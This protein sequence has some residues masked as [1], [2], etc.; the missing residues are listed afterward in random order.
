MGRRTRRRGAAST[1]D[2]VCGTVFQA[3]VFVLVVGIF[4][5]GVHFYRLS[6]DIFNTSAVTESGTGVSVQFSVAEG[7]SVA[8]IGRE[9][10]EGGLIRDGRA[11]V[12]QERLSSTHGG[13]QPGIYTLSSTMTTDEILRTLASGSTADSSASQSQTAGTGASAAAPEDEK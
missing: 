11:F 9:L 12:Y 4:I 6:Y 8:Q 7:E 2:R 10:Q 5:A 13:I 3:A 1:A